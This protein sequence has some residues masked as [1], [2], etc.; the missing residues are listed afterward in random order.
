MISKQHQQ[1]LLESSIVYHDSRHF[2]ATA[3]EAKELVGHALPGLIFEYLDPKGNPYRWGSG[4]WKNRPYYRLK[5]DWDE[6]EESTKNKYRGKDGK[7]PK[8]LSP[9]KSGVRPY[10]SSHQSSWEAI[11]SR[12]S[13][14]LDFS[15]G[16]KK[17][18]CLNCHDLPAI[19]L[20]GVT[21]FKDSSDRGEWHTDK[22]GSYADI[23]EPTQ[24]SGISRFLP[25]LE[26]VE[27]AF[28]IVGIVFDS[29]VVYKRPVQIAL[30]KLAN[31]LHKRQA[32]P[33]PIIL[34]SEL[35]GDK[36]GVDDFIYRHGVE[37]Y[38][39]LRIAWN[40][41]QRTPRH[42][43]L[44]KTK[45]GDLFFTYTEPCNQL[46]GL[47]AW[48]VLKERVCYRAGIGWYEWSGKK[49]KALPTD[50]FSTMLLQ[51]CDRQQWLE[52]SLTTLK[53]IEQHLKAR[54]TVTESLWNRPQFRAFSNGT[55]DFVEGKFERNW[56][57]DHYLT[58]LLDYDWVQTS[59]VKCDRWIEFLREATGND[60]PLIGLLRAVLR[61]CIKPKDNSRP[62]PIE[63]IFD[64][65]G[66]PG[67]GKG[68][69]LEVLRWLAGSEN[70]ADFDQ[71]SINNPNGRALLL[72][73]LV[74]IDSDATGHWEKV[75]VLNKIASNEPV[76]VKILWRNMENPR[77][78]TVLIRAMNAF[79]SVPASGSDGLNRRIIPIKFE[80]KPQTPNPNLKEQ[81]RAELQ[82]IS[83][84]VWGL[85]EELMVQQLKNS[86]AIANIAKTHLERMEANST[87]FYFLRS[88]YPRG[89]TKI[90]SSNLYET[91]TKFCE[92]SNLRPQSLRNFGLSLTSWSQFG[93]VKSDEREGRFYSIPEPEALL[94]AGLI[95]NWQCGASPDCGA[96]VELLCAASNPH[97]EGS[98]QLVEHK[99]PYLEIREKKELPKKKEP[100]NQISSTSC[101]T[102]TQRGVR[103]STPQHQPQTQIIRKGL[104]YRYSGA[105]PVLLPYFEGG[106]TFLVSSIDRTQNMATGFICGHLLQIPVN[107]LFPLPKIG[108]EPPKLNPV[109][110]GG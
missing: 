89:V 66:Q 24:H 3:E 85:D 49:W 81:L 15:E 56:Q 28:R 12:V 70:T 27:W 99:S 19:G 44:K 46:K 80:R 96:S 13:E 4:K 25:E 65:V 29:D 41:V 92:R 90:M 78:G 37:A 6:V 93:V 36:N 2:S 26:E 87:E 63:A 34:P 86:G 72:D 53:T 23:D 75:G 5:P 35:N 73:K 30:S 42:Q 82:W 101:T 79:Q 52:N 32:Q 106:K 33:F 94:R 107:D 108:E 68:T 20:A 97:G 48:S 69:F 1:Q 16:E 45:E 61:W 67:T 60:E 109:S 104:H 51:F 71:D 40:T 10:F 77:L 38:K 98:V 54:L 102:L 43:M 83:A 100:T 39:Q 103:S 50:E 7:L 91:Y 59:E 21:C 76:P 9:K 110:A 55:M 8:Y 64:L 95:P 84:W 17:A 88:E 47:M 105:D 18:D 31:E 62:F 58:I 57:R 11:L 22:I 14:S 74:A